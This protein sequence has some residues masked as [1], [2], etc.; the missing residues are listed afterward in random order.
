[1]N[2]SN[3]WLKVVAFLKKVMPEA[4]II[5]GGLFLDLLSKWIVQSNMEI[6][7]TIVVIPK[8]LNF[9]YTLNKRAAFGFD[10]GLGDIIGE[11]GT[12]IFFIVFTII[13]LGFFGFML[14]KN[15]RRGLLYRISFAL[16]IGG[17]LGN[18]YDR[19]ILGYVRDFIQI[20][21]FG[22]ELF[23]STTFAIFNIADACIVVGTI[24]LLIFVIFFDETFK[25]NKTINQSANSEGNSENNAKCSDEKDLIV[26][27]NI[28][29]SEEINE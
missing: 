10:F 25:E 28:N 24:L 19:A 5:V 22:L 26:Q 12:I 6:G 3:F 20:E 14:F 23:G 21:Y 15:P 2:K 9:S 29:Q 13:A 11:K 8:F 18:L 17:A 4:A 7:Q 1:M 27:E 16:I